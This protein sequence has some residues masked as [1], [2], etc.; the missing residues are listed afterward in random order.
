[1][2]LVQLDPVDSA[3]AAA[4]ALAMIGDVERARRVH[5]LDET[6][7]ARLEAMA[8][9]ARPDGWLGVVAYDG[10]G[11]AGYLGAARTW[12]G[13]VVGDLVVPPP[14]RGPLTD[15]LLGALHQH[16]DRQRAPRRV[17][18]VRGVPPDAEP[19]QLGAPLRAM[20]IVGRPLSGLPDA[21]LPPGI[22]V[23]SHV[24]RADDAGVIAA[25]EAAFGGS[26]DAG[27]NEH[28]LAVRR[29][30]RWYRADDLLVAESADG[31]VGVHWTKQRGDRVGEVYVL[32]IAPVAQGIGLGRALLR[33]GLSHLR[34]RGC[35]EAILW[36]DESNETALRLYRAEGFEP[37]WRDVAYEME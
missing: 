5:V 17:V 12:R 1:M 33:S 31:I 35:T 26:E 7:A 8:E 34:E 13:N 23:R 4:A 24:E 14:E 25:L 15:A 21:P 11:S 30:L 18:W 3:A 2:S 16:G 10:D 37:R 32:G 20:A 22:S 28:R 27:W 36:V 9:G 29:A 6:E 19:Q